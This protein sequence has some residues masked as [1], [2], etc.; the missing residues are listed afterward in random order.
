[1]PSE[2]FDHTARAYVERH[3]WTPE[4]LSQAVGVPWERI[5][6]LIRMGVAP[7]VVY[8]RDSQGGWWSALGGWVDGDGSAL[9]SP[10]AEVWLSPW[11]AWAFRR[12]VLAAADGAS[13][14][15]CARLESDRFSRQFAST[16][17]QIPSAPARFPDCF[18]DDGCVDPGN[19]GRGANEEW[20]NWL[21]GGYAVCLRA[22]TGASCVEKESLGALLKRHIADPVDHPMTRAECLDAC[23]TLSDLMLPFAPWERPIGT[24]G[25]TIDVLLERFGV[26]AERPYA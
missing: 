2:I 14:E 25:R 11:T 15:A 10:L 26:G 9:P 23:V 21:D 8:A 6:I 12:A 16:L 17:I 7:G 3:F 22:F 4:A 13:D 5:E 1:M 20:A 19:A 24:P 18:D